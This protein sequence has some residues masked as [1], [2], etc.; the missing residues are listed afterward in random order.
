[1]T[2]KIPKYWAQSTQ[3]ARQP[4]GR[5]Y[6]IACWQWSDVSL[7]DARQKAVDKAAE[8]ARRVLADETLN[9]YAYDQRPLREEMTQGITA[10]GHE[11][12]VVTRN[13]YGARVLNAT[14]AMFIDID[15]KEQD[16][17]AS[18]SGQ[19]GRL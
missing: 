14:Q 3:S 7:A 8:L 19:M 17:A 18:L 5:G 13:K 12:G 15:F 9:R 2:M 6:R 10:G 4:G 16:L 11:V 1:M